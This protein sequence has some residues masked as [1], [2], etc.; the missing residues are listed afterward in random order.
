MVTEEICA[1]A[2]ESMLTMQRHLTG[3]H[4][5]SKEPGKALAACITDKWLGSL[6]MKYTQMSENGQGS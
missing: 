5:S 6:I 1:L 4:K 3:S 2:E